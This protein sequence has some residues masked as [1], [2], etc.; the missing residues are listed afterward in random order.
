VTEL[1]IWLYGEMLGRL[2][3]ARANHL[4]F[5][6]SKAAIARW[7][8][9]SRIL[10]VSMP[11]S[12]EMRPPANVLRAFFNGL[13]PEG[14]AREALV[15]RYNLRPRDIIGLLRELGEDCA[16]AVMALEVGREPPTQ[17][18]TYQTLSDSDL[19]EMID[20]L[21]TSPLGVGPLGQ[22][23]TRKSLAGVQA[24][25]LLSRVPSGAWGYSTDGAPST[26]I[27]KPEEHDYP[28]GV[29]NEAWCMRLAKACG[30]TTVDTEVIHIGT[31][32]VYCVSRYDRQ[33]TQGSIERIHQED[34]CQA[35]GIETFNSREK[36]GSYN[37]KR[38][39][40]K[41]IA[42][43]LRVNAPAERVAL[44]AHTAFHVAIGN[45]DAHGKNHSLL[46][47]SDGTMQLAPM[48][49]AWS[50]VQY[51]ELSRVLSLSIDKTFQLDAVTMGRLINEGT[52]WGLSASDVTAALY[53][54]IEN[55]KMALHDDVL[56]TGLDI[57]AAFVDDV[58]RRCDALLR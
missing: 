13:L 49:D 9:G 22:A 29:S 14:G 34:A 39:T 52:S 18:W 19:A 50:T 2:S 45:A 1:D 57:S 55:L 15:R 16:G 25:L 38:M 6:T 53:R 3:S 54:V 48:Y 10:S 36:Y 27:L 26:H 40:L 8:T 32:P 58:M 28:G 35:L 24:K 30:L 21:P 33:V 31:V 11:L 17:P 41:A 56:R 4:R 46:H 47:P 44:L 23:T 5:D 7:G 51:P 37:A 42:D 12:A 20:R 43:I